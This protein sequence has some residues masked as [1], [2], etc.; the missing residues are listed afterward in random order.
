MQF[1]IL[2]LMNLSLA[3]IKISSHS[4]IATCLTKISLACVAFM[5]PIGNVDISI[6]LVTRYTCWTWI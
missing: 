2:S 3:W 6:A 1:Y 5:E 4:W